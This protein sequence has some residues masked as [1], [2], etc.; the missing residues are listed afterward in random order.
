[1][2]VKLKLRQVFQP[3]TFYTAYNVIACLCFDAYSVTS[4]LLHPTKWA[5]DLNIKRSDAVHLYHTKN[6]KDRARLA[7][8]P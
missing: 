3:V 8:M 1:M 4:V 7:F 5:K 2:Q 6:S